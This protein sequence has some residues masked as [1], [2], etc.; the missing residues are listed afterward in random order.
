VDTPDFCL[1]TLNT[2]SEDKLYMYYRFLMLHACF[3]PIASCF[4][5]TSWHFYVFFGTNLLTRYHSA[6]YCFLLFCVLEKLYRKY[7]RNWTKRSPKF[8]FSPARD[9]V[10]RRVGGGPGG[11]HTIGWHPWPRHQVVWAPGP[12]SD[13]ALLPI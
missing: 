1:Q 6:S 13:I 8:L 4:V 2:F 5:Y 9:G 12:P 10:Q 11:G 7:S 3:A